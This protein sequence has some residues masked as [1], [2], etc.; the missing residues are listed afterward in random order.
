MKINVWEKFNFVDSSAH[1]V[2]MQVEIKMIYFWFSQ[3]F[4]KNEK[5]RET[6]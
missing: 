6:M 2:I 3:D 4:E 5:S 1:Q